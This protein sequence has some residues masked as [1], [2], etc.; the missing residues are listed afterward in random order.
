MK[1]A[2]RRA[3]SA[4]SAGTASGEKARARGKRAHAAI[5]VHGR[6]HPFQPSPVPMRRGAVAEE[7]PAFNTYGQEGVGTARSA[8]AVLCTLGGFALPPAL[9]GVGCTARRRGVGDELS[10]KAQGVGDRDWR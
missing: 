1:A 5:N 8:R 6:L 4:T 7:A 9:L 2:S 3:S 10:P